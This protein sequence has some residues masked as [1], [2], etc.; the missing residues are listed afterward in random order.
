[1]RLS[2]SWSQLMWGLRRSK[3]TTW[4]ETYRGPGYSAGNS[5]L[6]SALVSLFQLPLYSYSY[7]KQPKIRQNTNFESQ[8]YRLTTIIL[9]I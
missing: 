1:M 6:H 3:Q 4:K 7:G 5:C 8:K 9:Q 2:T